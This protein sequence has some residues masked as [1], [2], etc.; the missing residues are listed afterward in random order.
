MATTTDGSGT[1]A[2]AA[3]SATSGLKKHE[4]GRPNVAKNDVSIDIS[5]CGMCHS[6]LHATNGDWGMTAFPI[7]PGHEIAGVVQEVGSNVTSFKIGDKVGVGCFVQSCKDCYLCE[8]NCENLCDGKTRTYGSIYPK[9]IDH[10][11]CA[12][13]LTHG[14]YTS[15][16]VVDSH[17]VCPIPDGMKLEHA[18]P[19]LCAGITMFS[20]ISKHV[21]KKTKDDG[22][23]FSVGIVG[24]GG[25]GHVGAKIAKAA[26]ANVTVISR[27]LAKAD[28]AKEMGISI[29]AHTDE[30]VMKE[31]A[32]TFDVIFDTVAVEH[33]IDTIIQ[34]LKKRGTYVLIGGI[35]QPLAVSPFTLIFNNW[36]LEGSLVGGIKETNEMLN[37]CADHSVTPDIK[38][39]SAKD[40]NAHFI[41]ML[42]GKS[43]ATRAVI[44]M[45]TIG[46]L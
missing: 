26:G 19:L 36:S 9:G 25:L 10:D 35:P 40:A 11:E 5:F 28:A 21:I 2:L 8:E 38:V 17:F 39:I 13:N 27:S 43:D 24:F 30:A 14:G 44:D 33:K 20:P 23:P 46:D 31:A 42:E 34:T 41:D 45:S 16:I 4:L 7:A 15:Q 29:L 32:Q 18:G 37:F 1:M 3:F 22:K 12:G 6:D